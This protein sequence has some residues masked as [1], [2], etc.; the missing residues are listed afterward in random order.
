M[1]AQ[2]IT[3]RYGYIPGA[4]S[5]RNKARSGEGKKGK[6]RDEE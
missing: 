5:K 2:A 3:A 6:R 1:L 4:K